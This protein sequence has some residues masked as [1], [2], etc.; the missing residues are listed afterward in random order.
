MCGRFMLI[1]SSRNVREH[2][3]V[4]RSIDFHRRYNIAPS[5]EIVGV[6]RSG[7][8]SQR[9]MTTFR[10]GLIPAWAK[11][12]HSGKALINARAETVADKPAFRNAFKSRRTLIPANGFFEWDN[13]TRSRSPYLIGLENDALFAMG[14]IWELS[15]DAE[16]PI[17]RS[18]SILTTESNGLVA[19]IH[20][21]MPVI[22]RKENYGDWIASGPLNELIAAIIFEPFPSGQMKMREVNSVVNKAD[23]DH[24]DCIQSAAGPLFQQ[25]D[26]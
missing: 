1:S 16:N 9:E 8:D 19:N 17:Q 18:C 4:E 25:M 13:K 5:Q 2:F 23:Y 3:D 14:G 7:W 24:P 10:W 11:D 21:R 6:I 26:M 20:D 12:S 15:T 22:V